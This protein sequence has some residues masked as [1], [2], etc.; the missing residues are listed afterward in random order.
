V[1]SLNRFCYR[2]KFYADSDKY[3]FV[4]VLE[5]DLYDKVG[6]PTEEMKK[7]QE[8][9]AEGR[10]ERDRKKAETDQKIKERQERDAAKKEVERT[11]EL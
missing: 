7:V 3:H 6:N 11:G 9:I 5:G 8:R 10:A 2:K 1:F 4:G